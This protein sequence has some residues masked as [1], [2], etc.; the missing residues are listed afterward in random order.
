MSTAGAL[1]ETMGRIEYFTLARVWTDLTD[2][3]LH[4]EPVEGT[5]G[6]RRRDECRTPFAL[7]GGE[8][9]AEIDGGMPVDPLTTIGWLLWHVGSMPGRLVETEVFGGP[10]AVSSGWHSPYLEHHEVAPTAERAIEN[11][12]TG[13]AALRAAIESSTEAD[14]ARP[15]ARYTYAGGSPLDNR[16]VAGPPGPEHPALFFVV[17][18]INE[19][20]HHG[21]QICTMRDLYAHRHALRTDA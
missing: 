5:W 8:W 9:V 13:W 14:L 15:A 16:M 4:W 7:G 18:V 17:S 6:L 21:S 1:L 19:V 10:H 11:L 12:R 3:E 20:S 2:D